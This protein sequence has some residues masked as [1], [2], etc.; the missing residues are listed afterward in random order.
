MY[1]VIQDIKFSQ[2]RLR[3]II[4][5]LN[6][7]KIGNVIKQKVVQCSKH[8]YLQYAEPLFKAHAYDAYDPSS[9]QT[10]KKKEE[11]YDLIIKGIPLLS[12]FEYSK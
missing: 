12:S 9:L 5:Q 2:L 3:D 8:K 4:V 6:S 10:E 1:S 11:F 7:P